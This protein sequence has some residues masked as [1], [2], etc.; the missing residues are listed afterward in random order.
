MGLGIAHDIEVDEFLE[1]HGLDGDVLED[2]HEEAGDILAVRHV[3]DDSPDGFLLLIKIIAIEFLFK[4]SDFPRFPL[5]TVAHLLNR[6]CFDLNIKRLTQILSKYQNHYNSL[7]KAVLF[8][9][10]S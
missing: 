1:L 4:L 7:R 5:V 8:L 3:G 6:L 10:M 9:F 2:I